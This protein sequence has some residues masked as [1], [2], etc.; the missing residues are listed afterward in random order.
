MSYNV[1]ADPQIGMHNHSEFSNL[2]LLD[3]TNKF[4]KMIDYVANTLGQQGFA[5]TDHECLSG[6]LKY[7][8]TAKEMKAKGKIP[9][10]FKPILGNEIYLVEE[11]EYTTA[12]ENKERI[13]FYHF[14]LIALDDI[15]HAQLRELS[16]RAWD[17][18]INY[19]GMQRVPTYMSDIEEI[20]GSNQ[21][22]IVGSTACLG[23][24]L[25][26]S[27]LREEYDNAWAFV[28]W[29][30]G[31]FGKDNFFLE[32]QPHDEFGHDEFGNLVE[33]EQR[34]VNEFIQDMGIPTII[35][36]DA[37]YLKKED[38]GLHEAYLKSDEDEEASKSGGRET[39]D[40]YATAYFMGV[41]ELRERLSYLDSEFFNDCIRNS[42]E[43]KERVKGYDG[44]FKNQVIPEIPLPP[45]EEWFWS[46]EIMDFVEEHDYIS[47]LDLID[48]DNDY[49]KYLV[50][51]CFQGLSEKVPYEQWDE[52]LTRFDL[53]MSELLGISEAKDAVISSY[54]ITMQKFIDIIWEEANSLVGVSRGSGAG[55][56]TNYL[57]GITQIN[58]LHQ[59][60]EMPHWRFIT[61]QRV[62]YP[63]IDIDCSSYKKDIIMNKIKDYMHSIG[64][65]IVRVGTFTTESAKKA[66]QTACR[67]LG[68]PSDV[69]LY[70]SSLIPIVRG[71]TRSLTK[72]YYGDLE[73]GLAPVTEFK[74]QVDKYE[75]LL[76][77]AL[78]IEGLVC[79]RGVHACGVIPSLNL[80]GSCATM[81]APKGELITQY[82]LGDCEASGLIKYDFLSTKTMGMIQ[83]CLEYLVEYGHMDWQG[84]LR[85][86]YDKYLH[87]NNINPEDP[88]YYEAL[89][90]GELLSAFQFD[91]GA[92]VK[93]LKAI[94]PDSLLELANA[95]SL[96]RLMA[97]D[98]EQPIDMYVRY[99]NNPSRWEQDMIDFGLNE[100]ERS[101]LHDHLDKDY[102]VCSS[103]EGMMLL[104]MDERIANFTVKE[105]NILRKS[106]AKKKP[107][108]LQ[109]SME[110]LYEKGLANGCREVFLEYIWDV[111]IAMQ[112]GYSFSILHTTGYSWI[113]IQ[114]LHLI[115]NYPPIYWA[116]SVLQIESGA[117]EMEVDDDDEDE[118]TETKEKNTN[119]DVIGGA[120]A[121]LQRQG[122]EI[123]YPD[124]NE[125]QVGFAPNEKD[126][127]II[128]G[129]K[130]LSGV[131]NKVSEIIMNNRPY[132]S[133]KDFYE[134]LCLTKQEVTL[135]GGKTQMKALVGNKQMISLIKSG[136][137]DKLENK[138]RK[139]IMR[140]FIRW[141]TPYKSSLNVKHIDDL[142]DRGIISE[143]YD[144]CLQYYNFKM[145][146]QG[147]QSRP[148]E[149]VKSVKW[150]LLDGEDAEDT[151][152]CVNRFFDLFPELV[153][154]RH[155]K[156]ADNDVDAYGEPIWVATGGSAKGTF[157][158][159][160]KQKMAPLTAFMKSEEC[161]EAYNASLLTDV[162]YE[163]EKGTN[164]KWEMESMCMYHD[165]HE[166]AHVN[167]DL[168]NIVDF[169]ELDEE[170]TVVDW[171]YRK[172]KETG[173]EIA[174]PKFRIDT[175][176]GTVL[177]RNKTKHTVSLLTESGVVNVKY[178]GGQFSFYDRQISVPNENGVGKK[179]VE[180]SWFTRGNIL[181]IHGIRRGDTFRPKVYKN[182]SY[183]HSTNLVE[184]VYDDGYMMLQ[185]E[186]TQF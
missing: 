45:K 99:K 170:P 26:Q 139:E 141:I 50:C 49:N 111:Q 156:W 59:P 133:M 35:T 58:P 21:G 75:G 107:K 175:I 88:R 149:R 108:L 10:T 71:S 78:A 122:V 124:I 106:V 15:G 56:I 1:L 82:D 183:A 95:N 100:K 129:F 12:L 146:L 27:I 96:M 120:I 110:L 153:E 165:E 145:Y 5:L 184:R 159:V 69:G 92:G 55:W 2:R 151:A 128:Y 102:G 179:I 73:D 171:W 168:Y 61:A 109:E 76:E 160:Y 74:N 23:G 19:R 47:I 135:K 13:S 51:R 8:T 186:R 97:D 113:A 163:Y 154:G 65:D 52:A 114:Q 93:A 174:I 86:T 67:G 123:T 158:Y 164:A 18:M 4:E 181:L 130:S 117:I 36:T 34:I 182:T 46:D 83:V 104:S 60:A 17:R 161:L 115:T 173:E 131:N 137:F 16:T 40:F 105:S 155:W 143:E 63:D 28:E 25:G 169:E 167:K 9:E 112:R 70:I 7:L 94:K 144:E 11:Q 84:S 81:R 89:N 29:C 150:F 134:R 31:V 90:N 91:S 126:N 80:V 72:T 39:G 14:I 43:I 64:G 20:I 116:C 30:Q 66:I 142:I 180:R 162:F 118:E 103:Q 98:G 48:S 54:F 119:Y 41:N 132:T 140:D 6:H 77:T 121:M 127:T 62:D 125:A 147:G 37:H 42:W 38:R 177:G 79:G 178:V 85:A 44:L 138:P 166:V 152:Y 157:E 148:D 3:S 32:M 57:M 33:H 68:I 87:P 22:H 136:A 172:D 24:K 53:E 185:E 101:I 176:C